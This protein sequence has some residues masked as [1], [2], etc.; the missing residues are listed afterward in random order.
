MCDARGGLCEAVYDI[1][2]IIL[3]EEVAGMVDVWLADHSGRQ[4]C[5]SR[6]KPWMLTGPCYRGVTLM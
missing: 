3:A 6:M 4:E 2:V 1:T 5:P